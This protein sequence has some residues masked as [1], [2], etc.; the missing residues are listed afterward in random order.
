MVLLHML[1]A[2]AAAYRAIKQM[3]G[4][5]LSG[6]TSALLLQQRWLRSLL[7]DLQV[8]SCTDYMA[9]LHLFS[10]LWLLICGCKRMAWECL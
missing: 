7:L 4:V 5:Y 6:H 10:I 8:P 3:P 1:R 9:L 2:H